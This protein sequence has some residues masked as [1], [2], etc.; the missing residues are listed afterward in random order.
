MC[1]LPSATSV[2]RNK[3]NK[4]EEEEVIHLRGDGTGE[5]QES[6]GNREQQT[7]HAGPP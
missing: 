5:L 1:K 2:S 4:K 6:I 3:N 7:I